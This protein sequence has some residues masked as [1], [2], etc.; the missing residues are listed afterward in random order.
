VL[1]DSVPMR[2]MK[3][4]SV[5]GGRNGAAAK[6]GLNRTTLLAKMRKLGISRKTAAGLSDNDVKVPLGRFSVSA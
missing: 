6:L 1:R 3:T 4:D 5:V 2:Q